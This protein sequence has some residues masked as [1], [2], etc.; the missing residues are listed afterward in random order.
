MMYNGM[1][2]GLTDRDGDDIHVGDTVALEVEGAIRLFRVEYK[3][4]NREVLSH[5]DFDAEKSK[6]AITGIVFCWHGYD[7]FPCVDEN[8]I[9]DNEKMVIHEYAELNEDDLD[10]LDDAEID[11]MPPKLVEI[12]CRNCARC[13]DEGCLVYGN[14]VEIAINRCVHDNFIN[15][16]PQNAET[17]KQP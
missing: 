1:R 4:V 8:G 6:V 13:G 17:I 3:T 12:D 9:P 2:T 10:A 16:L 11:A 14:D 7:L 15:Y 5:P